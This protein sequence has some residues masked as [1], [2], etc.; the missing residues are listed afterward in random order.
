VPVLDLPGLAEGDFDLALRDLLGEEAPIS[1]ST[2]ARLKEKGHAEGEAWQ[3]Q[4]LDDWPVVYLWGDGISVKAGVEKERAA[5]LVV[6]AGLVDG[7]KVVVAVT[8][9]HRESRASWSEVLRDLR[10]RGMNP[11][12]LVMGDGPLRSWGA[13]RKVWPEAD[14]QRCGNHKILNGRDKL[15]RPQHGVANSRLRASASAPPQAQAKQKRREF[16]AWGHKDGDI[17]A[18]A[19]RRRDGEQMVTF[20]RYPKELWGPLRTTNIVESPLAALR[21]R[22]DAAKWCKKVSRLRR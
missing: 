17:Q 11:P 20:S 18:A 5:L 9:G 12:T 19:K 10:E 15:P 6:I 16:E 7:R 22:T 2:V 1:A 4:R 8:P 13:L 21:L 3:K 14:H